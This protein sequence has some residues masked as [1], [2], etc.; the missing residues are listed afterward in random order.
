MLSIS[1][2]SP[3]VRGTGRNLLAIRRRKRFIPAGAGNSRPRSCRCR[4]RPVHPRGCGEQILPGNHN[5]TSYGSSPRVRGTVRRHIRGDRRVRFI[6]AGAG[7]SLR[8]GSFCGLRA[9]HPRGCGEQTVIDAHI[10]RNRGSSPRVRGTGHRGD[11]CRW[12][13]R[14]IPAGAGNR[15][16]W[17]AAQSANAVHPRGC[18]EQTSGAPGMFDF[19]GSSPRVRGTGPH[20]QGGRLHPRF[21]PA[22][23]GNSV[24]AGS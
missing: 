14:F 21:I 24:P 3:R 7:N 20:R 10:L 16:V 9:V 5:P 19:H 23:A 6:P 17:S 2:S 4:S 12:Q 18:G 15:R 1:G 13:H 8:G 11:L 22:G